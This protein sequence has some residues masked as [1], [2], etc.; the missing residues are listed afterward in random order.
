MA[1]IT[2]V[3]TV[4]WIGSITSAVFALACGPV[5]A[6]VLLLEAEKLEGGGDAL[7]NVSLGDASVEEV[8]TNVTV[9]GTDDVV[10]A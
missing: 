9:D 7:L 6:E 4:R 8:W 10:L 2:R 1:G 3:I 5:E